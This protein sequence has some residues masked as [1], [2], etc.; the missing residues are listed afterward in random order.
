MMSIAIIEDDPMSSDLLISTLDE[1]QEEVQIKAILRSVKDA[2]VFF[3][4]KPEIDLILSDVQ[5]LDGTTFAIFESVSVTCPIVFI[6]AYD[7]YMVNAFEYAGIDYLLKPVSKETLQHS[8]NKYKALQNHFLAANAELK[9]FI[10][11]FE[12]RRTRII[13]KKGYSF[14]SLALTDVIL[15]YTEN[16]VV[17]VI[18]TSGNKYLI[19]KNL[20]TLEEELDP[21]MFFRAN[22]QYIVNVNFIQGYKSYE[23]VKL[24]I[25]LKKET[26]HLIVV[27]Q[28]KAKAFRRWI[29]ET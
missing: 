6:S 2:V 17:Y 15:F 3:N 23:R 28:E 7:Q 8:I 4:G 20:N 18:D 25:T 11:H 13:V 24:I 22:R 19:D 10:Q 29:A 14:I 9:N 12:K 27:G 21:Q 1:I 16:L 5:L 26:D